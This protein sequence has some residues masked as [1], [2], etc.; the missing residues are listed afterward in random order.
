MD[1]AEQIL[2]RLTELGLNVNQAEAQAGFPQGYIRGVVR[3]DTKRATPSIDKAEAIARS[4]GLEFYLGPIRDGT[5]SQPSADMNEFFQVPRIDASVSAGIGF[6]N[7]AEAIAGSIAFRRDWLKR[8]GVPPSA[9]VVATVSGES[10]MPTISPGDLLL[11]NTSDKLPV[12]RTNR[13]VAFDKKFKRPIYAFVDDE[14]ARVKRVIGDGDGGFLLTSDNQ[15]YP[16]QRIAKQNAGSL[17]I[18]GR[19]AWWGHTDS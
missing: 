11:I 6:P 4:L 17:S 15:D 16:P 18:I 14:G 10:M 1:F 12:S 13:K 19:V 2:L 7:H 8:I 3:D 5:A 9:A